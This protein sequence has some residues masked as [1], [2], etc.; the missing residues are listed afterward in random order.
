MPTENQELWDGQHIK[1]YLKQEIEFCNAFAAKIVDR[2]PEWKSFRGGWTYMGRFLRVFFATVEDWTKMIL[3]NPQENVLEADSEG[4]DD[5][6]DSAYQEFCTPTSLYQWTYLHLA[7]GPLEDQFNPVDDEERHELVRRM[8]R[9]QLYDNEL[10]GSGSQHAYPPEEDLLF[11]RS[12]SSSTPESAKRNSSA[13]IHRLPPEILSDIFIKARDGSPYFPIIVSHV[14]SRCRAIAESTALLWTRIHVYLPLSLVSL[15]LQRSNSA[16]LD[17]QI[18][19]RHRLAFWSSMPLHLSTFISTVRGH[20]ERIA[21]LSISACEM[22]PVHDIVKEMMQGPGSTYPQLRKLDIGCPIWFPVRDRDDWDPV[23]I[24]PQLQELSL[25]GSW[26][27]AWATGFSGPLA[28]LK[29]LCLENNHRLSTSDLLSVL[30]K[31]PNLDTLILHGCTIQ[32]SSTVPPSAVSL[33]NLTMLQYV[34]LS[35]KSI[36]SL[37]QA[38]RSPTLTSLKVWWDSSLSKSPDQ[39]QPLVAMLRANPQLESLDLC[40]CVMKQSGWREVFERAG[41]L[42]YLRLLSCELESDDLD[43]LLE[44]GVGEGV[45]QYL[46]PRLEHLILENVFHLTTNHI[47][48]IIAHRPGIRSLELRGWDGSNVAEGDVQFIQRSVDCFILETFYRGSS[49][50][51]GEEWDEESEEWSSSGTPSEGSWLSGDG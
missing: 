51:E 4:I 5:P 8:F 6:T 45:E 9:T 3:P 46:L 13:F 12:S 48:Q 26:S 32:D 41:S 47:R 7:V 29:S 34:T 36:A 50:F 20:R 21:L 43:V 18:D 14:D 10:F 1:D 40:Q 15:Y 31:L 35:H 38:F 28:G 30:A 37:Q 2:N 24:P 49:T 23:I 22:R 44:P 42:K 33:P 25:R 39:V 17:V 11:V 19:V 27:E 16:L